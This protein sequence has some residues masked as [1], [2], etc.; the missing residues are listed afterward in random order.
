LAAPI[1]FETAL[2]LACSSWV[3]VWICLRSASSATNA[4]ASSRYPRVS[5]RATTS[6][7]SLRRSWISIMRGF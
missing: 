2:R 6:S 4:A 1:C 3:R 7:S 5:S